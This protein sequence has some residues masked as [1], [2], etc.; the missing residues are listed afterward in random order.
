MELTKDSFIASIK[1]HYLYPE[2]YCQAIQEV[3]SFQM[4]YPQPTEE[5]PYPPLALNVEVERQSSTEHELTLFQP[6]TSTWKISGMTSVS[7]TCIVCGGGM[8][9]FH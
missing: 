3:F 9:E 6:S 8:T 1:L 5:S 2:P 4:S 7:A